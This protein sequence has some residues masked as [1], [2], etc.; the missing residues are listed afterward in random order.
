M[1][2]LLAYLDPSNGS[3]IVQAIVGAALG[4]AYFTRTHIKALMGRLKS[5]PKK[6]TNSEKKAQTKEDD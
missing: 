2:L 1:K 3:F 5:K 4:I 6:K